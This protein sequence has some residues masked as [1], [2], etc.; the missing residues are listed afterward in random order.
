MSEL[1]STKNLEAFVV[2]KDNLEVLEDSLGWYGDQYLKL[3]RGKDLLNLGQKIPTARLHSLL[4]ETERVT[5]QL[6]GVNNL[7]KNVSLSYY[8]WK[9]YLKFAA[10]RAGMISGGI[11]ILSAF[12]SSIE[13]AALTGLGAFALLTSALFLETMR[14]FG[15]SGYD[16]SRRMIFISPQDNTEAKASSIISKGVAQHT[17]SEKTSLYDDRDAEDAHL[18]YGFVMGMQR[19]VGEKLSKQHYSPVYRY[20]PLKNFTTQL[21]E[22]YLTACTHNRL[23]PKN[24]LA[25]SDIPSLRGGIN[26]VTSLR[27]RWTY[28]WVLGTAVVAIGESKFGEGIYRTLLDENLTF[29]E[30]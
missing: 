4:A 29:L 13:K 19:L 17:L 16:I 15:I 1:T 30:G 25:N 21:K 12:D 6:L 5:I 23:E 3:E 2:R 24:S 7:G 9:P 18:S 8:E 27:N 11:G 28:P 14:Q 22:A 26:R 10:K 20:Q